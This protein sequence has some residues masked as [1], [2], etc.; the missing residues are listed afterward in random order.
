MQDAVRLVH[1]VLARVLD[2]LRP[3]RSGLRRGAKTSLLRNIIMSLKLIRT[4]LSLVLAGCLVTAFSAQADYWPPQ[5]GQFTW[6]GFGGVAH[7]LK[8]EA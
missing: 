8:E 3:G 1:F 5:D 4:P 6:H 2:W 7:D